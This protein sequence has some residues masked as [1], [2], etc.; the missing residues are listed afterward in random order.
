MDHPN[1]ITFQIQSLSYVKP[2]Q[3]R[4]QSQRLK[5]FAAEEAQ[6]YIVTSSQWKLII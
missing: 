6:I 4:V 1:S 3:T 5:L 2:A